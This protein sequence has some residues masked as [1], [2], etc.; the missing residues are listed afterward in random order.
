MLAAQRLP[1]LK[2]RQ[3][4]YHRLQKFSANSKTFGGKWP[5]TSQINIK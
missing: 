3:G 1:H 4:Q 2:T 5:R